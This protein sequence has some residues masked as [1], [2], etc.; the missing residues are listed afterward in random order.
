LRY[1]GHDFR[2][3]VGETA[4]CNHVFAGNVTGCNQS[5]I[6]SESV[7]KPSEVKNTASD[8]LVDVATVSH[9]QSCGR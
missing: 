2:I 3:V 4:S 5:Q 1:I 7:H 9:S 6:S 8:V